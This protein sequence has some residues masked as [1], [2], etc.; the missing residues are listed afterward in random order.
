MND[1]SKE[2]KLEFIFE[3]ITKYDITAYEIGSNTELNTSGVDRILKKKVINP[4]NSSVN[5]IYDY[6]YNKYVKPKTDTFNDQNSVYNTTNLK[7][8]EKLLI[9]EKELTYK[10]QIIDLLKEQIDLIKD[11]KKETEK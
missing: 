1:L 11:A 5:I 7:C 4:Q 3:N 10:D 2:K 9:L 8:E 6:I